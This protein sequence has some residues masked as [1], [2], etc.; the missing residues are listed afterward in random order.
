MYFV[1]VLKSQSSGKFYTG[2]TN[3]LENRIYAHNNGM[4]P[5]TKGKGPWEL[6]YFEEC[7]SRGEAMKREKYL[8]TGKGR[9]FIKEIIEKR[10]SD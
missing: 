4:S 1:Y 7:N 9:E 5:Y 8:K 3:N 2:Q 6:I 10:K